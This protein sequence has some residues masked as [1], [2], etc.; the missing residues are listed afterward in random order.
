MAKPL[1]HKSIDSKVMDILVQSKALDTFPTNVDRIV[2]CAD[3]IVDGKVDLAHHKKSF[4]AKLAKPLGNILIDL[5]GFVDRREKTIYVDHTMRESRKNFVKLHETGHIILPWQSAV[6]NAGDNDET[7]DHN[8]TKDEFEA[9]ANFFASAAFFQLD[10]FDREVRKYGLGVKS[11]QALSKTFGASIHAALRRM[12]EFQG[13]R[14][15]LVVLEKKTRENCRCRDVFQ[16]DSFTADF[17]EIIL[18]EKLDRM[19]LFAADYMNGRKQLLDRDVSLPTNSGLQQMKYEF[20][21]N[22]HNG[23]VFL[24]PKGELPKPKLN[25]V[26]K[27]KV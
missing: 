19:F 4:F 1:M 6:L 24:Y 23:F 21:F 11:A 2:H 12:V 9:E 27:E 17:G 26:I 15:A 16:S 20:F 14:C 7:L 13:K 10:R 3:L 22:G 5:R 25:Y 18:P 8:Y